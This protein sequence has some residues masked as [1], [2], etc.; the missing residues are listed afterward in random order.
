VNNPEKAIAPV[1]HKYKTEVLSSLQ[2]LRIIGFGFNEIEV[3]GSCVWQ[4]Q[5]ERPIEPQYQYPLKLRK[6]RAIHKPLLRNRQ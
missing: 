4:S 5:N 6:Q 2:K 1:K 3:S